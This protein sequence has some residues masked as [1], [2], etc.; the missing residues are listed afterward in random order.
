MSWCG[1]GVPMLILI[2][3]SSTVH[4]N[5]LSGKADPSLLNKSLEIIVLLIGILNKR[6]C[7]SSIHHIGAKWAQVRGN[8]GS[9]GVIFLRYDCIL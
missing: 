6:L 2:K 8:R 9:V 4:C 1:V 3:T 7:T 5:S